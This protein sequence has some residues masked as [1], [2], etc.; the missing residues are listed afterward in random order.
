MK[1]LKSTAATCIAALAL[2]AGGLALSPSVASASPATPC[3]ST[4][5]FNSPN[6][7]SYNSQVTDDTF[8]VPAGVTSVSVGAEGAKGTAGGGSTPG[9]TPGSG[10]QVSATI[11]VISG[12][13]YYIEVGVGGGIGTVGGAYSV[14]TSGA[15]GG[16]SGVYSCAGGATNA[17]CALLVAAGGG[18]GGAPGGNGGNGGVSA[19][20]CSPGATGGTGTGINNLGGTG[21]IG[22]VGGACD[23]TGGTGGL[24]GTNDG[25]GGSYGGTGGTGTAGSGGY[26]GGNGGGYD[27]G[28][29]GGAGYYG[30]GGGGG[31][32]GYD[33]GGGGGGGGSSFVEASASSASVVSG[34]GTPSVAIT[35]TVNAKSLTLSG[36]PVASESGNTYSITLDVPSALVP[37]GSAYVIDNSNPAKSCTA[38]AWTD[39]G[40]D[41]TGGEYFST[42]CTITAPERG[43]VVAQAY[44]GGGA[45]GAIDYKAI[46][47][48]TLTVSP[49]TGTLSLVG[50]PVTSPAGNTYTPTLDAST[51]LTPVGYLTVTDSNS[52]SCTSPSWT[53]QGSDGAGGELYAASCAI[54]SSESGGVTTTAT[55]TGS[56]YTVSD[57][58]TITVGAAGAILSINEQA[59]TSESGNSYTIIFDASTDVQPSGIATVTDSNGNSCNSTYTG[60]SSGD[61]PDGSGGEYFSAGCYITQAESGGDT[62]YVSYSGADYNAA[63]SPLVDVTPA[64]GTLSLSGSPTA[65]S[66]GNTYEVTLD[67][68]TD[69]S[70]TGTSAVTDAASATCQASSWNDAGL[71][72]SGGELFTTSCTI[73][74]AELAG[75]GVSATYTGPDYTTATSNTLDVAPGPATHF[76]V[77]APPSTTAGDPFDVTVTAYDAYGDVATSYTGTVHFAVSDTGTDVHVPSDYTFTSGDA[78]VVT[79]SN[80]KLVTANPSQ[81]ITATDTTD[82][83][84]TGETSVDVTPAGAEFLLVAAPSSTT[85]GDPF[86]FTVTAY[87][88]YGNVATGYTGTVSFEAIGGAESLPVDYT[89]LSSDAGSRTFTNGATLGGQGN[90]YIEA[91][92]TSSPISGGSSAID[93]LDTATLTL[94]TSTGLPPVTGNNTYDATL[95]VPAGDVAP[96]ESVAINDGP[97]TCNASLSNPSSD[98]STY[99]GSCTLFGEA[100]GASITATYNSDAGDTGYVPDIT[101]NT[102]T[103][104]ASDP[105]VY[106]GGGGTGTPPPAGS[107]PNATSITLATNT[108]AYPGHTFEGWTDGASCLEATDGEPGAICKDGTL[109]Y[110]AGGTYTLYS[111][112]ST[113]TFT[114]QWTNNPTDNF[115]Y[116]TGGGS[117]TPPSGHGLDGTTTTLGDAPTLPGYTFDGWSDGLNTYAGGFVYTLS[118]DGAL[119]TFTAQWTADQYTVSYNYENGSGTPT[120]DIFTVGGSPLTL[121]TPTRVGYTFAGWYTAASGGTL[122]GAAADSYSPSSSTD[123]FAQ[124]TADQYTVNFV[125]DGGQG[126]PVAAIF[127]VGGSPLTL[128]TITRPNYTFT[129]WY[130]AASGGTLVGAGG[131]SYTPSASI[132]LYAQ[133]TPV[134]TGPTAYV[135]TY[136]Y[137]GGTGSPAVATFTVGGSALTL[138]TPTLLGSVFSGWYTAPSG[139]TLVGAGGASY[140]PAATT[141]LYALWTATAAPTST[142]ISKTASSV[143]YGNES[144]E[145]FTVTVSGVGAGSPEGTVTVYNSSTV[146]CTAPLVPGPGHSS[147]SSCW[148]RVAQLSA[149]S[150]QNVFATYTPT[151]DYTASSSSATSFK[152]TKD[153]TSI[154]VTHS[155][156]AVVQHRKTAEVFSVHVTANYGAAVPDG[157]KIVV[158][159]GTASCAVV[160]TN[161]R[162]RCTIDTAALK[163]GRYKVTARYAGG[164]NLQASSTSSSDRLDVTGRPSS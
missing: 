119:V 47:S 64:T 95:T 118:S 17:D 65:S 106:A 73:S 33:E 70:P 13:T 68:P 157:A 146:L 131:S 61:G 148:I 127:T 82:G 7:C 62:A 160:L 57:S 136:N 9:S 26:G 84:I 126:T 154:A 59:T 161:G 163:I 66:T 4:G 8:T 20:S 58:N 113:V 151:N 142:T 120:S 115:S 75:I 111:D 133:W 122:A 147:T 46:S 41:G 74:S 18:G 52:A 72:G 130:T 85:S 164:S 77:S 94:T 28:G 80:V 71:D 132:T 114:A 129:G 149:G 90:K 12:S 45:Y 156:H 49:G 32:G 43:G 140:S 30:G 83:S 40:S 109:I 104:V 56:D 44:Y 143:P 110:Q 81:T 99:T 98:G 155:R 152:V 19:S 14:G 105:F 150:Y 10:A 22:G 76:A 51:N 29:G 15:G 139:G 16:L 112:G 103:V 87:D 36:S 21:G 69:V 1:S 79:V 125:Y 117:P 108:F 2:L 55:Y 35:W 102:L 37:Q 63:D 42:S 6:E 78:G 3:G 116:A 92:D 91:V 162:G 34:P 67:S 137:E 97:S 60:W 38:G 123:L 134:T 158:R 89:F 100:K 5:T 124:W 159:V 86:T 50:S 48:N 145:K 27:G 31:V 107:V 135:V 138:P 25:E 128:P 54:T 24:G 88:Q 101:S 141:T 153:P 121:P 93:V 144:A 23:N 53:D 39:A 96:N 11:P